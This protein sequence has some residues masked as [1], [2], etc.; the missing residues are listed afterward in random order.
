MA[1][2]VPR[3]DQRIENLAGVI[4]S[5]VEAVK[6]WLVDGCY[7]VVRKIKQLS[8]DGVHQFVT[9]SS[10][11][12]SGTAPNLDEVKEIIS[13]TRGD[14]E[15]RKMPYR[16]RREISDDDS[17]YAA[18]VTDPAYLIWNGELIIKPLPA[19]GAS[20]AAY[21]F[22]IPDYL[23][24]NYSSGTSAID[25]FPS[26][27][28]E[29]I[30]TYAA[31]EVINRRLLDYDSEVPSDIPDIVLTTVSETLPTFTAPDVITLPVPPTPLTLSVITYTAPDAQVVGTEL[32]DITITSTSMPNFLNNAPSYTTPTSQV[33]SAVLMHSLTVNDISLPAVPPL[34][35]PAL[36]DSSALSAKEPSYTAPAA[37]TLPHLA[38]TAT[39]PSIPVITSTSVD[40]SSL[41]TPTF[42]AP[43]MSYPDWADTENWIAVEED[44]ELLGAR[45]SE[46]ST[47][48]SEYTAR[49][50]EAKHQYD[51]E[52]KIFDAQWDELKKNSDFSNEVVN[53]EMDL[54]STLLTEYSSEIDREM[55]V[56]KEKVNKE[57][58]RYNAERE[59]ASSQFQQELSIYQEQLKGVKLQSDGEQLLLQKY[60][61]ELDFYIKQVS[62]KIQEYQARND[63]E[64]KKQ[65]SDLALY[66][67]DMQNE[68]NSFNKES[69]LYQ[70]SLQSE[71]AFFNSESSK[72]LNQAKL[73][74]E[75]F[76][77]NNGMRQADNQ[78]EQARKIEKAEKDMQAIIQR[79][80]QTL[81]RYSNETAA[82]QA[83]T[84]AKVQE[85]QTTLQKNLETFNTSM[86][87]YSADVSQVNTE[88]QNLLGK[89][90][91]D[92]ANYSAKIQKDTVQYKWLQERMMYLREK[93][94]SLFGINQAQ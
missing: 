3:F 91:Q 87:K 73:D 89:F 41:S 40:L 1:A 8:P 19:S 34:L 74:L 79:N 59:N 29:H 13:V 75:V 20:H 86:A 27:F 21:Y 78:L 52:V 56:F 80:A 69:A 88:N 31:I 35:G 93:Y 71:L 6:Q 63:S 64:L 14:Y 70:A 49:M 62:V 83:E 45:I 38:I 85:F 68:L 18:Q 25:D 57:I 17:I 65:Q 12:T 32:G 82:Y 50:S 24:Q 51:K 44:E 92:L 43:V 60:T 16:F 48:I 39:P 7:D 23:V 26:D 66:Q 53:R 81:Q 9:V 55:N 22:Y 4:H 10:E 47:K 76:Q 46:I 77:N 67:A 37:L 90:S 36:F 30:C 54:Y 61:Q 42:V 5:D 58:Q 15:C 33:T 72:A 28:Y 84:G 11:I 2:P 94:N